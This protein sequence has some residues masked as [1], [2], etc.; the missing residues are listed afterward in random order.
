M[1]FIFLV[2]CTYC[3]ILKRCF[4]KL[5]AIHIQCMAIV[6]TGHGSLIV[7]NIAY[8]PGGHSLKLQGFIGIMALQESSGSTVTVLI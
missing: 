3:S 6:T 4:S 1:F 7:Q 8:Y 2:I 5:S